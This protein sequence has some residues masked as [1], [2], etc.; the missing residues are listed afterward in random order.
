MLNCPRVER[1]RLFEV[2]DGRVWL[3]PLQV[4]ES[5]IDQQCIAKAAARIAAQ[6]LAIIAKS[7]REALRGLFLVRRLRTE[8]SGGESTKQIEP[9][10]LGM[11]LQAGGQAGSGPFRV[12]FPG[13]QV[14]DCEQALRPEMVR[15]DSQCLGEVPLGFAYAATFVLFKSGQKVVEC[16]IGFGAPAA[17]RSRFAPS[18]SPAR[19]RQSAF[20]R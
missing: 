2:G 8:L 5:A 10:K 13:I 20:N 18:P 6:G 15:L 16:A 4:K 11:A 17:T 9:W 1:N 14:A 7:R 3:L 19:S 12:G